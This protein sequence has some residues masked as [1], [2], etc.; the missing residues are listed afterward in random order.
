MIFWAGL[1]LA[2]FQLFVPVLTDLFDMQ[3]RALH[4]MIASV[5]ILLAVPL[6]RGKLR[7]VDGVLMAVVVVANL[8]VFFDWQDIITYPGN[9]SRWELVLGFVL[10]LILVDAARRAAG[11]AIPIMVALMFVYVFAGAY[12][13][14]MWA[15]PGFPLD[16]VIGTLDYSTSGI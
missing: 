15:H 4:V 9:A 3:L 5:T 2:L 7:F 16:H 14:G 11:W 1:V 8:L 6:F 13:P 10:V 12:M